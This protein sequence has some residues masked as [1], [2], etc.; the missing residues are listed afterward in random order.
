MDLCRIGGAGGYW[1][2]CE[3]RFLSHVLNGAIYSLDYDVLGDFELIASNSRLIVAKRATPANNLRD[4]IAWLKANPDTATQGTAGAGSPAKPRLRNA[5]SE[6]S[7]Q[8]RGSGA[9]RDYHTR[10]RCR[11]LSH[12]DVLG[13]P[14]QPREIAATRSDLDVVVSDTVEHADRMVANI[15]IAVDRLG[16]SG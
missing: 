12:L 3:G 16:K 6:H 8:R 9:T 15:S 4:L 7:E 13:C 1:C 2:V 14:F 11:I 10:A 5:L